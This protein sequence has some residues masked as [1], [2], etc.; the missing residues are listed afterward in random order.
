MKEYYKPEICAKC[1]GECCKTMPAAYTPKD[2]LRIF[3]SVKK[4]VCSGTVAIDWWEADRPL[5]FMR[6]KIVGVS[7]LYDPTWGGVCI[8]YSD[9][10]CL[11]DRDKMPTFCK[12]LEPK[13]NDKCDDHIK[14]HNCKYLAGLLWKRSKMQLEN[15]GGNYE[16]TNS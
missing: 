11:L 9:N 15:L 8:H 3:G 16:E 1:G 6:P 14:R 13:E 4:A 10:G 5:Y 2:I 7:E 12:T